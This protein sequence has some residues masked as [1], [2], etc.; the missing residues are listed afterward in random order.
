[1]LAACVC[2][3]IDLRDEVSVGFSVDMSAGVSVG[4]AILVS[5]EPIFII[6]FGHVPLN[7]VKALEVFDHIVDLVL[8]DD[9]RPVFVPYRSRHSGEFLLIFKGCDGDVGGIQ[10]SAF[11]EYAGGLPVSMLGERRC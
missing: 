11:L 2:Q 4:F 8:P 9:G 3:Q 5:D 1:M 10:I 7:G 6:M